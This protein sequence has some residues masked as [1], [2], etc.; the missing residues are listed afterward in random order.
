MGGISI[1]YHIIQSILPISIYMYPLPECFSTLFEA[2]IDP[3]QSEVD[4]TSS[5][6]YDHAFVGSKF[7]IC[8]KLLFL[9]EV[10]CGAKGHVGVVQLGLK[11][12][13][14]N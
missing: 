10:S 7:E 3:I 4:E 14:V 6:C 8:H 1:G 5:K 9:I 2:V 12:P 11:R 13:V